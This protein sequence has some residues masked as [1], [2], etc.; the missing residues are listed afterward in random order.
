[1]LPEIQLATDGDLNY[2]IFKHGDIV[3]NAV[4]IGRAHV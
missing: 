2:V 1:M 4:Q 3:T